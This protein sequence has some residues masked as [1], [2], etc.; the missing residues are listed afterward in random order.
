[1]KFYVYGLIS[2]LDNKLKYIGKGSGNRMFIHIKSLNWKKPLD[3]NFT[4]L[5]GLKE[6]LESGYEDIAYRL[7]FET[8]NE[9]EAYN[10]EIDYI[11]Q[12]STHISKGGWNITLGGE[13]P[14]SHKGK[15]RSNEFKQKIS[16]ANKG[17]K[18]SEEFK[19]AISK[20]QKGKSVWNKGKTDC[21]SKE[22]LQKMSNAGKGRK[23]YWTGKHL[24]EETK[25]K[26]SET[27]KGT[28]M[29]PNTRMAVL[30]A[31][32]GRVCSEETKR[33]IGRANRKNEN[34]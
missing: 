26:I 13:N 1:M 27:K 33:K 7:F 32:T 22:T 23:G 2:P 12:Y 5:A 14:P 24:S 4:K 9:S 8:D 21:Y 15:K 6:I 28:L 11:E 18:R 19:K 29:H 30:E 3:N 10:K 20:R 31:N 34:S 17:K 25:Q 16:K